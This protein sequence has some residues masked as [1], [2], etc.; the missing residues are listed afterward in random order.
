M[1]SVSTPCRH[2]NKPNLK[3]LDKFQK[4]YTSKHRK[5]SYNHMF[6]NEWFL[7]FIERLPSQVHTLTNW[8]FT[9]KWHNTL[10]VHVPYLI[11]IEFRLR[12]SSQYILKMFSAG[13][14]ARMD[15]SGRGLS[16]PFKS[17]EAV[18][19][20]WTGI[21]RG[22]WSVSPFSTGAEY[23]RVFKCPPTHT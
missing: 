17:S 4:L 8:R 9:Y 15:T 16:P 5:K 18:A 12:I 20:G 14:Y 13:V 23:S 3:Y 11:A 21:Q 6:E 22:W 1:S 2:M 7:S 19:N 10:P